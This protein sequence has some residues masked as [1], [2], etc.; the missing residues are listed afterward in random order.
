MMHYNVALSPATKKLMRT[1]FAM[2]KSKQVYTLFYILCKCPYLR[3]LAKM[4]LLSY[5]FQGSNISEMLLCNP[6]KKFYF[7]LDF[8]SLVFLLTQYFLYC[9]HKT[10]F[11]YISKQILYD[12]YNFILYTINYKYP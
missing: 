12:I 6:F 10:L 1:I 4:L 11:C 7:R 5:S 3:E 9:F 8:S 2:K